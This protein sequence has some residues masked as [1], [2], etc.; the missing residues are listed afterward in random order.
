MFPSNESESFL[1]LWQSLRQLCSF[2]Y[3]FLYQARISFQMFQE[4]VIFNKFQKSQNIRKTSLQTLFY[5]CF[6]H[7]Y[8]VIT[9]VK[10]KIERHLR[11]YWQIVN[12]TY[13]QSGRRCADSDHCAIFKVYIKFTILFLV[14][15]TPINSQNSFQFYSRDKSV[16]FCA[17]LCTLEGILIIC[18][19][20]KERT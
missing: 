19:I 10:W 20:K 11:N 5:E 4:F 13:N 18:E 15:G 2:T 6:D 12:K 3:N 8:K 16:R 1:L 9:L 14:V 17:L 7:R